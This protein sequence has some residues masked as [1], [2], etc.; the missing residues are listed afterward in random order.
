M[1]SARRKLT[2]EQVQWAREIDAK[3]A[4]LKRQLELLPSTEE[5]AA[6]LGV[7]ASCLRNLLTARTYRGN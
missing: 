1:V 3:R 5:V 2:L 4:E 6:K 7:S